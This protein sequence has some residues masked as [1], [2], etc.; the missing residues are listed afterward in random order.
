MPLKK[1]DFSKLPENAPPDPVASGEYT[2]EVV[3][4]EQKET[5]EGSLYINHELR[6]V[7]G[8]EDGRKLY[9]VYSYGKPTG[10]RICRNIL[11]ALG[12]PFDPNMTWDELPTDESIFLGKKAVVE[13]YEEEYDGQM[14]SRVR[15]PNAPLPTGVYELVIK[16]TP[17]VRVGKTS[18]A[19]YLN[20]ESEVAE[21]PWEGSRV[22]FT[23]PYGSEKG[24]GI[25]ADILAAFTGLGKKEL[26]EFDYEG[27]D[28]AWFVGQSC[29]VTVA[30]SQYNGKIKA[31]PQWPKAPESAGEAKPAAASEGGSRRRVALG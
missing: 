23:Y 19:E 11:Y 30:R 6:V 16:K 12:I 26:G 4:S 10:F 14:Q 31:E 2:V 1:F 5:K 15:W 28:E 9:S 24:G 13:V 8:A 7:G 20:I 25:C 29:H 17:E 27:K 22:W 21:G 3:K 18:G